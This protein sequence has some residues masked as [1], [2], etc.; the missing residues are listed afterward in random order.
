MKYTYKTI[1]RNKGLSLIELLK[2]EFEK[3]GKGKK[4]EDYI[5]FF[6]L[7]THAE[8]NNIPKTELIY[9]HSK[10]MIVDDK[11]AIIGSA[12]INDRSMLGDRDSEVAVLISSDDSEEKSTGI[13]NGKECLIS[14]K[15]K[16]LRVKLMMVYF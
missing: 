1:S 4:V 16:K 9:I 3:M 13:I 6:S 14:D 12:N 10:L 11:Y 5:Y 7:R 8:I 2:K 15:V